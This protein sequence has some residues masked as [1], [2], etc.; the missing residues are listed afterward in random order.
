MSCYPGFAL[1]LPQQPRPMHPWVLRV[2]GCCSKAAPCHPWNPLPLYPGS[3]ITGRQPDGQKKWLD[4]WAQRVVAIGLQPSSAWRL[5]MRSTEASILGPALFSILIHDLEEVRSTLLGGLEMTPS[6]G[7]HPMCSR[8]CHPTG[9]RKESRGTL[10]IQ[11]ERSPVQEKS[12]G[13]WVRGGIGSLWGIER[14]RAHP[15]LLA[16]VGPQLASCLEGPTATWP[17]GIF[18]SFRSRKPVFPPSRSAARRHNCSGYLAVKP[19]LTAEWRHK[20]KQTHP[21]QHSAP[22]TLAGSGSSWQRAGRK[23]AAPR[24]R[25][26]SWVGVPTTSTEE[27]IETQGEPNLPTPLICPGFCTT[28]APTWL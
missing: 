12:T 26:T 2:G 11:Q 5:V 4:G 18:S 6:W 20:N 27:E 22:T 13:A 25:G 15:L 1:N 16:L 19:G 10:N 23:V 21:K 14:G 9:W 7:D 8:S 3:D 24:P 17:P 28:V